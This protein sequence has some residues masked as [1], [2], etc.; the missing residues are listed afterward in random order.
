MARK[1]RDI[2]SEQKV[3]VEAAEQQVTYRTAIYVRKSVEDKESLDIQISMLKEYINES[4]DLLLYKVYSDNGFTG[5][6]FDRPSFQKM[7]EE[8]KLGKFNAIIVKDGSRLGRNYLEA[9]AYME[10]VFPQYQI[11]FISV[12]DKYD[13]IKMECKKDGISIPLKNIM[14]E[15]Y[16]KDLSRKLSSA[17]RIRQMDGKF[18]GGL[19][20][21]GYLKDKNDHNKLVVDLEVAQI[22]RRIFLNKAIGMSDGAIAKELNEE[23]IL[24]PFAYR[25]EK[26]L[27]KANKYK[28]MPW[29]SGTVTQ[30]LTN[31]MYLG[32]MVQGRNCQSISMHEPE[33]RTPENEW[34][35][36]E[37]THEAIIENEL[38]DKVQ[39]IIK[40]RKNKY[41]QENNCDEPTIN[42]LK[43]KVYCAD[44]GRAMIITKSTSAVTT[45]RYYRCRLYTE[46]R[47]ERCSLKSVKKEELEKLI[48]ELIR[49][50]IKVY[51]DMETLIHQMN[52]TEAA[53][54]KLEEC[55]NKNTLLT[56]ES[57]KNVTLVAGLYQDYQEGLLNDDEY[58]YIK[59]EYDRK[60]RM[61]DTQIE[62]LNKFA[63]SFR[64]DF[65]GSKEW[66]RKMK[67][68]AMTENLN[69]EMVDTFISRIEITDAKRITVKMNCTDEIERLS[70]I[71]KERGIERV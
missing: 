14:N 33:H 16:S 48:L 53:R 67:A 40:A 20:T 23:R 15:Q 27:V 57:Q 45:N 10:T 12:N 4:E 26:G 66:S 43:G 29:K 34:I 65:V 63:E 70:Q 17:F 7:I 50:H 52:T 69:S 59:E 38:Y 37:N 61:L 18:I 25:Y 47:G 3:I 21:Y 56:K 11:R 5:I 39:L 2:L 68:F 44:C 42:L 22:V 54:K 36:V 28:D 31:P 30:M 1:V 55:K 9:G 58:S 19:T 24:S 32:H 62:E 13:S 51:C 35:V 60:I 71:L 64:A 46:T 8:M 6:N 49:N 41:H